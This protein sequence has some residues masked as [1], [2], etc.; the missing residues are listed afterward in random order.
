MVGLWM[1]GAAVS[2]ASLLLRRGAV[3]GAVAVCDALTIAGGWL[4]CR[5]VFLKLLGSEAADGIGYAARCAVWGLFPFARMQSFRRFKEE[6]AQKRKVERRDG[7]TLLF[8][9][10]VFCSG[11]V[12]SVFVAGMSL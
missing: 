4:L 1:E 10:L 8:G 7:A 11:L 3:T 12:F 6:R 2:F 9:A 5:A